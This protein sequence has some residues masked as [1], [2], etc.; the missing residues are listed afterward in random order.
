MSLSRLRLRALDR[1]ALRD[2]WHL[3]SQ[4]LAIS[5]ILGSGVAMYVTMRST[6]ESLGLTRS[7]Y[8]ERYRFADVFASV[9]RAPRSLGPRIAAIPGVSRVEMR[10]LAE[11]T[12]DIEGLAEP[13]SGRLI[14]I[15]ERAVS[16]LNDLYLREGRYVEPG[17]E[18]EVLVSEAFAEAHGFQPG[19]T[20]SA[21]I[22]GRRRHLIMVGI[23]LSPEFVYSVRP[24]DFFPDDKRFGIFW[25]GESPL[26]DAYDMEGA[27]NDLSLSLMAGASADDV[28][29]RLDLLIAPYGGLGAYPRADQVSNW[30]LSEE[31]DQLRANATVVPAIFLGV[32][33]FL[34]NVVLARLIGTQRDQIGALKAFG[35]FHWQIGLIT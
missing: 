21:V 15:P 32:A 16:H 9:K 8:Y 7:T 22:N 4:A 14:S 26:A 11:V 3:R 34:L 30:Y 28:I 23:A 24:G 18:D 20:V 27:F 5:L 1:K 13:A 31:F 25:M 17:R 33:A 12:L 35:Y 29:E 19:D 6:M 2:L 10:I